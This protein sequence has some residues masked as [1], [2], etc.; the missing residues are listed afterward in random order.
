[1]FL[2]ATDNN[3]S[4]RTPQVGPEVLPVPPEAPRSQPVYEPYAKSPEAAVPA[5]KPYEGI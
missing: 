2:H 1:M 4:S 5:Y 3:D